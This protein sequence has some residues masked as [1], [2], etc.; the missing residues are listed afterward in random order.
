MKLEH[1]ICYRALRTRDRRFDGRFFT[2]VTSTG[3]YCRPVC[4]ARTPQMRHC[5]FFACAAAAEEAGFRPCR[6]C[7]PETAPGTPAWR[8]TSASVSR[9]L[10]LIEE[11]ALDSGSVTDL[12]NRLGLGD[13]QLRRLFADHLGTSPRALA[14][15]RRVHFA[16]RMIE[17]TDLPMGRIALS[18]GYQNVRRFNAAIQK[19]FQRTPTEIR[20]K[21]R[22]TT[23]NNSQGFIVLRLPFCEPCDWSGLL[24]WL[25]L[26]AIPGVEHIAD[27]VYQRS[28]SLPGFAGLIAVEKSATESAL[29]LKAP[30]AAAPVVMPL[31]DRTRRLFDLDA[32]P[33]LILEQLKTDPRLTHLAAGQPGIR[34]PGCWEPFELAVR[35]ILGQQVSVKG[36]TAL[37]GRLVQ[38][39][40]TP[41]DSS[42]PLPFSVFPPPGVLKEADIAS[43][44]MP[45]TR[46]RTIQLL[47]RAVDEGHPILELAPNLET[48]L[49]RLMALPGVGD[50]TAQY[51]AMRGLGEPDAFPAGD[52]GLRKAL[53]DP[54]SGELPAIKA[55]GRQAEKWRPWRSYAAMLLWKGLK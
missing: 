14:Q 13:R 55:V 3:I 7:R 5:T 54:I 45:E 47:A 23:G 31:V 19:T 6:R 21:A 43:I 22:S 15:T 24:S 28:V 1:P 38:R 40:G 26:R 2:G 10:R 33:N 16:K 29:L 27:G 37:A 4:P 9:A 18:A 17:E 44:G 34:V 20:L 25:S 32:D 42:G 30:L 36:A 49:Q 53:A 11:G 52:L 35:A 48:A 12:A 39:F 41:L 51:I 50:W 46:A 8:G